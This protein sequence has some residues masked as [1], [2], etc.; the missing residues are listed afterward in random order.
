MEPKQEQHVDANG[1]GEDVPAN[2]EDAP[3]PDNAA[4]E[5]YRPS[6]SQGTSE[7]TTEDEQ[8]GVATRKSSRA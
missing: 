1:V 2:S 7:A 8:Q 6:D 5:D 3:A 4:D